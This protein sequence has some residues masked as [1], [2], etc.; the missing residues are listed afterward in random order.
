MLPTDPRRTTLGPVAVR[1]SARRSPSDRRMA[2]ARGARA[3]G[4]LADRR[5]ILTSGGDVIADDVGYDSGADGIDAT[6]G[7]TATAPRP[8]DRFLRS[9][10]TMHRSRLLRSRV[11]PLHLQRA[12]HGS[13]LVVHRASIAC[14][15]RVAADRTAPHATTTAPPRTAPPR[16][17]SPA[18]SVRHDVARRVGAYGKGSYGPGAFAGAWTQPY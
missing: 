14:R 5:A 8:P 16:Q 7:A 11:V 1:T 13:H 18:L 15:G 2:A 17:R 10:H 9:G 3:N 12:A 4:A 6:D